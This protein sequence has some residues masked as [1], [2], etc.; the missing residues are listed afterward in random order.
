MSRS[1]L[2]LGAMLLSGSSTWVRA[3]PV[4]ETTGFIIGS[5]SLSFTFVANVEPLFYEVT[6]S[7]L[8]TAPLFGFASLTLDLENSSG[9]SVGNLGG[10]GAFT[11]LPVKNELYTAQLDAVG[12][13][14]QGTGLF[15]LSVQ[16]L[17]VPVPAPS[18]LVLLLIPLLG[19]G[20]I[21]LGGR[22]AVVT[23]NA[24]GSTVYA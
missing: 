21:G 18:P 6:L 12:A 23:S 3:A 16:S 10:P 11:F 17:S 22:R 19:L 7:D 5:E 2:F 1:L 20:V 9:T 14:T 4:F 8:S 24:A 13:G 15:G